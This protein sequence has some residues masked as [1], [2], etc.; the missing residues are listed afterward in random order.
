LRLL[1]PRADAGRDA[2]RLLASA[3]IA[4]QRSIGIVTEPVLV[5][6]GPEKMIAAAAGASAVVVG[7][8]ERWRRDGIGKTRLEIARRAA[9]PVLLVRR[10]LRPGGLA[11][12]EALT[13]F[14]WS[15]GA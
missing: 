9:C 15:G 5:E 6:R 8:S 7:L 1:G 3:S 10:G 13:R 4:L 14:T 2:S 11:P 12:P